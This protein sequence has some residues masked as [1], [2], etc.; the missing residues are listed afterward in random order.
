V[1]TETDVEAIKPVRY[2]RKVWDGRGL[3]GNNYCKATTPIW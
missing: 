2:T 1:L 3:L